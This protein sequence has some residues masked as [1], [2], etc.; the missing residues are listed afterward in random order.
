MVVRID[1]ATGE[2]A[3]KFKLVDRVGSNLTAANSTLYFVSNGG[4]L[5]VLR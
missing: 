3:W 5:N 4:R 1:R 2:I